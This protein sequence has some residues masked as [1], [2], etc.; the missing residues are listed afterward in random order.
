MV[1]LVDGHVEG[2]ALRQRKTERLAR[3]LR[4]ADHVL[5]VGAVVRGDLPVALRRPRVSKI[6]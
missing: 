5:R 3:V 1:Q 2:V 4:G 6:G